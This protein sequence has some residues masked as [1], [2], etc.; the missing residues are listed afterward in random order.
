MN[1]EP[2]PCRICA[3]FIPTGSRRRNEDGPGHCEGFDRPVHSTDPRCVLFNEQ[4]AWETRKAQMP[5]EQRKRPAPANETISRA[6][7]ATVPA[8]AGTTTT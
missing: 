4:G 8:V 3:R 1:R 7:A 2:L 5:P 6:S